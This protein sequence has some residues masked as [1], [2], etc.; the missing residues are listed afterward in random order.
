[1][2]THY[3]HLPEIC[4]GNSLCLNRHRCQAP[5]LGYLCNR[6]WLEQSVEIGGRTYRFCYAHF[7]EL[8]P[9]PL[10]DV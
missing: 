4:F 6:H 5:E 9:E 1:M 7:R 10:A 3:P 8:S 2:A